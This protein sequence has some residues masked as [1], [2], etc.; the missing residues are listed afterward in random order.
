MKKTVKIITLILAMLTLVGALTSCGAPEYEEIEERLKYLIEESYKVNAVIFGDG[1]ETY[2]RVYEPQISLYRGEEKNYYYYELEDEELGSIIAYRGSLDFKADYQ[3]LLVSESERDGEEPIYT[4]SKGIFYYPIEYTEPTYDFYYT[5]DSPEGYDYVK[6]DGEISSVDQIKE[7]C[8]SVYSRAYLE[9]V[10]YE[11]LF[12]GAVSPDKNSIESLDARY[13]N[14]DD[15]SLGTVLMKSN[16]YEKVSGEKR[17]FKYDT[18][19]MVRPSNKNTVNVTMDT[20][21]ESKPDEI[22]SVR[23]TLIMQDGEWYLD[24][25][26]Y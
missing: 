8:E 19:E 2:E 24:S 11:A 3:Y 22:V 5:E 21:L 13:V 9:G 10:V 16:T 14:Y 26:T 6:F 20:Y 18:A 17:I 12:V 23:I 4:D 25:P 15:S 1:L 7:L